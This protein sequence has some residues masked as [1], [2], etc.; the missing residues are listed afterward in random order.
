MKLFHFLGA[1]LLAAGSLHAQTIAFSAP[2]AGQALRA[3]QEIEIRWSGVPARAEEIELLLS[4]G[5]ERRFTLRVTE[6]L[7]PASRSF[8][9]TVPNLDMAEAT[10]LIRMSLDEQEVESAPSEPFSIESSPS[11]G[12]AVLALR[13][14]E[15]W[16]DGVE[17]S[18]PPDH[19]PHPETSNAAPERIELP[20]APAPFVETHG[21]SPAGRARRDH[22]VSDERPLVADARPIVLSRA[23]RVVPPRI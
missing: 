13:R 9:W 6:S 1:G 7:E 14:G 4:T 5:P 19:D 23:P 2:A 21:A 18:A 10:L 8:R 17:A 22:P 20:S 16:L 3:G 12:A 15:L 11:R